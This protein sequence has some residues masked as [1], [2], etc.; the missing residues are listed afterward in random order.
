MFRQVIGYGI[1][2]L[3]LAF[4]SGLVTLNYFAAA[5]LILGAII[6]WPVVR[7]LRF[8]VTSRTRILL[9]V[10]LSL[11]IIIAS[12]GMQFLIFTGPDGL[13]GPLPPLIN[14]YYL[15]ID[16]SNWQ[17]GVFL[18]KETVVIN[19][20]WA[21]YQKETDIPSSVELPEREVT[22]TNVGLLTR[23][24]RIMPIQANSS[25][26]AI[27]TLPDGRTLKGSICSF[28]C[29][30]IDIEL[31]DAPKG[32]F[33]VAKDAEKTQKYPYIDTETISW[34]VI[35]LE[36]GITFAF[37]PPPFHHIRQ[38]IEPLLGASALNQWVLGILGLICTIFIT[39]IV[40][41]VI[42]TTA[43]KRFGSWLDRRSEAKA[44]EETKK[45]ATI[46]ISSTGEEKEVDVSE[47]KQ[48][49]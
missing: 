47:K 10:Y 25:G 11:I 19:P 29:E 20:Q 44:R 42:L 48:K 45:K 41:P 22:S 4:L 26:N 39:P 13:I 6:S 49:Q 31:H 15:T 23:E 3:V 12:L 21:K 46:I 24:V 37:I 27:I 34:S 2:V 9:I 30:N 35:N 18:I 36:Q 33:L 5:A 8:I 7:L 1:A 38:I 32:S 14:E 28:S 43:Q 40:Q 16:C 17:S